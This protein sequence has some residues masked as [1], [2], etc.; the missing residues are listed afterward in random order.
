MAI[1][2]MIMSDPVALWWPSWHWQFGFKSTSTTECSWMV[3]EVDSYFLKRGTPCI[4]TMLDCSKALNMCQFR[5]WSWRRKVSLLLFSE[6]WSLS[7]RNRLPGLAGVLLCPPNLAS[8]MTQDKDLSSLLVS[9]LSTW[10]NSFLSS[11]G[12]YWWQFLWCCRLFR[13][14]CIASFL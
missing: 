14:H 1:N 13:W 6:H 10:M 8:L 3:M 12:L 9:L 2:T 11:E 7:M 5:S 4:V